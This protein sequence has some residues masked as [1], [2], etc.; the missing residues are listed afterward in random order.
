MRGAPRGRSVRICGRWLRRSGEEEGQPVGRRKLGSGREGRT[1]GP[2][3]AMMAMG[4][5]MVLRW[6]ATEKSREVVFMGLRE[7]AEIGA[8]GRC[9]IR[10]WR[11]QL[12]SSRVIE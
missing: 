12:F 8:D 10:S 3:P 7:I 9:H 2:T 4:L 1:P 11:I 6:D 5:D